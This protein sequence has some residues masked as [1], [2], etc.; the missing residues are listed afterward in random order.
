MKLKKVAAL[1]NSAAAYHLYDQVDSTGAVE[2]QWLGDGSAAYP[3]HGLPYLSE[4]EL[5]RM[6]DVPEK[7]QDKVYFDHGALPEALCVDDFCAGEQLAEDMDVTISY[8]GTVLLPLSYPGGLLYIQSRY[9]GPLEDQADLLQLYIRRTES[10]ARY[11]A[12]KTGMLLVG[13]V[14]PYVHLRESFS[15]K[16]DEIAALTRRELERSQAKRTAGD[17][18]DEDQERFFGS[19][20]E[21]NDGEA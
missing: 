15:A 14:F 7:K 18:E 21:G 9:L 17:A 3:L 20:A 1:C 11:V 19:A 16:L 6:F 4:Q 2:T 12:A 13:I 8:G 10:G 5:Y